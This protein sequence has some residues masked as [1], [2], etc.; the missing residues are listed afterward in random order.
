M[1]I[2]KHN[3]PLQ[4]E[5]NSIAQVIS[6]Y[7]PYWPM[8]LIFLLLSICGAYLYL[9]WTPYLYEATA[10]LIIKDE[11]RGYD[12]SKMVESLDLINTKKII[13]NEIEVLQSTTLMNN[14]VKKLHLYAPIIQEGKVRSVSA[15]TL[16]PII[17]EASSPDS[18]LPSEVI[19]IQYGGFIFI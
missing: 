11:K 5:D 4:K 3:L 14:V 17:I 15:Y 2:K 8:F 7:L 9:R 6:K 16:S 12:D 19:N 13:E 1:H 10:K 18:V